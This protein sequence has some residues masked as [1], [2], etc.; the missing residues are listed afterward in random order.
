MNCSFLFP[1]C[2][3]MLLL[4][5]A[6]PLTGLTQQDQPFYH[7]V[8]STIQMYMDS[9]SIAG[10]SCAILQNDRILYKNS[11]GYAN[12]EHRAPMTDSSVYRVWS[13]SKQFCA[14]SLFQLADE[15]KL[16]LD[17]SI[18]A[19]LDDIPEHWNAITIR[20]LLGNT[21][22]I[23]D[24]L[25]DFPEG[26][27]LM[28]IP[29]EQVVD[30]TAELLFPPGSN[31]RYS[32]SN[33]WVATKLVEKIS[34]MEYQDY[35]AKHYFEPLGMTRTFKTD[36]ERIVPNRVSKYR[37]KDGKTFNS[38]RFMGKP[39]LSNGDAELMSTLDDLVRWTQALMSGKMIPGK[40][41]QYA[42]MPSRLN[43]GSDVNAN[44]IIYYDS[45]S[46]Y[47]MGWF[48]SNMADEKIAWTPGAGPG[49]STC[50]LSIPKY[51]MHLIVLCNNRRFLIADKL[52]RELALITI[53]KE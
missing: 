6:F 39:F 7:Q 37:T 14:V 50:I 5:M 35:L 9:L 23:K 38:T 28:G 49:V 21:A 34:G 29:Y 27:K 32:N 41:L 11:T 16:N 52:A 25:N 53:N 24:Y 45:L 19:Y 36:D 30:S 51:D 20:Q 43:D 46:T 1:V 4:F 48:I 22:G 31:W 3:Y 42:W 13:V 47:G 33:Y 26:R 8:D 10:V 17:D 12:L 44:Y 2:R 40:H 18:N 15:N